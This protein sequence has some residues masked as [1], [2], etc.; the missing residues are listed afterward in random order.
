LQQALRDGALDGPAYYRQLL[1]LV[2]RLLFLFV[3]EDRDALLLPDDQSAQ[4]YETRRRYADFYS[5]RRLRTLAGRRRGGRAFDLY[6]QLKLLSGWLHD[7]GQPALALP[8]LGSALWDPATTP[9]IAGARLSN[10]ALLGAIH[11]LAYVEGGRRPVD[12]RH[13]GAEEL[14][15]VYESLLELHPVI[16]RESATFTLTTAAG[17]ERKQTGSYYT[18]TSLIGSLLETALDPVIDRAARSEQPEQALLDLTVCDPACGSG[19]FLIAAANRIAKRLAA[20]REQDPEPA[21]EAIRHAL[22]DVVSRCIHGVDLNPMAV[23]LCKVSLWLEALEPGRP[24]SFLDDR[25]LRGNSLLGATPA[26]VETGVPDDAYKPLLGDD[27]ETLKE[28]KRRNARERKSAQTAMSLGGAARDASALTAAAIAVNAI[29]DDSPE[30]VRRREAAHAEL[31][32]RAEHERLH[33]AAEA[34][35]AAFVA[36]RPPRAQGADGSAFLRR[37]EASA[38]RLSTDVVRRAASNGVDGLSDQELDAVRVEADRYAPL[39]WHVAFPAIFRAGDPD[40][41]EHG[42]A[43]GFDCVLGNPPWEHT[44][45]KEKEFFA[46]RDPAVAEAETGAKR[47]RLIDELVQR[48][49]ALHREFTAAKRLADGVS[50]LARMSG[51]YPMCGRGRIN[52]YAIFAEAMRAMVAPTGRLGIIVP[53]GIATD[54]TT[55]L[56]FAD[57]IE[58]GSLVSLYDFENAVPVFPGVHRSYK[59]CLLTAAGTARQPGTPAEFAFFTHRVEDLND[60]ERRFELTAQDIELLN[61]NTRTCPIFRTRR[62]AEITKGIYRR[63][64]VLVREGDPDGNPWGITFK[65]GLFNMTSDSALFRTRDELEADG[66]HLEGNVFVR[67]A[68]RML[69]LYEAK[70][71]HHF[72]HQWA[73]YER[74]GT[75]RDVTP[76]EKADPT[77]HVMPRYWVAEA[78]VEARLGRS[79]EDYL[80]GWREVGRSTDERT[81]ISALIPRAAVGHK[82]QLAIPED[83]RRV[84][85]LATVLSSL[86]FDFVAR[87]KIGGTAMSYFVMKQLPIPAPSLLDGTLVTLEET[88]GHRLGRLA[89]QL[90]PV[91]GGI[92][93][94]ATR[95]KLDA[96]V[97][98]LYGIDRDDVDYILETF[99]IVRRKDEAKF[100]EYRTK[101][102]ILEAYDALARGGASGPTHEPRLDSLADAAQS[103]RGVR[104]RSPTDASLPSLGRRP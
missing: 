93:D 6:E 9:Q 81:V 87:Q 12:F 41:G 45:L 19:H 49:P 88:A 78:E 7:G 47:K 61:P 57:L 104:R 68:K 70:M 37:I 91:L 38:A 5:T 20:V 100:G 14:G 92:N 69:P 8:A 28:W 11:H 34:W 77:F 82:Y 27:K 72:D 97:F 10:Q 76:E 64:P 79:H 32:A 71:I 89:R 13:L 15:S 50:H 59:F 51:R 90:S 85:V 67:D 54:D 43:G 2:Y 98:H 75:V 48:D 63:V 35:V 62:D 22:R 39:H 24:L 23:E 16:E 25:I 3:A 84:P 52:S 26:L 73:T 60:P 29:S 74:D 17:H 95:A 31:V 33:L 99:P 66:W 36:P 4:R 53:T 44:E 56:F 18:P 1:R 101:R 21:P 30:G 86:A 83:S 40:A 103:P 65:Q 42:W 80:L 46:T 58:S 94:P 102:L 55:K 96:T